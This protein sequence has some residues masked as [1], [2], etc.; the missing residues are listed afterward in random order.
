MDH[1]TL[2]FDL[3]GVER[4]SVG[5]VVE[6]QQATVKFLLTDVCRYVVDIIDRL[7]NTR[8]GIHAVISTQA[9]EETVHTVPW[10]MLTAIEAHMLQ[11]VG[12]S[13]LVVLLLQTTH[14]LRQIEARPVLRPVI[15]LDVIGKPIWQV[16]DPHR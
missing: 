3:C 8:I 7:F 13:P 16:P 5:P 12:Q 6:H 11:E 14:A 15:I 2:F 4:E 10:E 1:T 9:F